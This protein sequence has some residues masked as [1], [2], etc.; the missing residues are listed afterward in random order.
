MRSLPALCSLAA[1]A[2]C[3]LAVTASLADDVPQPGTARYLVKF[4]SLKTAS[5]AV[6]AAGGQIA[7]E[8][9]RQR[10]AV[11]Y[12]S[13]DA[14]RRLKD[15]PNVESVEP[16]R[17]RYPMAQSTPY[18]IGLV[19]ADDPVLLAS[20]ASVGSMVCIID[21]GY[22]L[23]HEDL[24]GANI[25]GTN[26]SGT[27]N[28]YEDSCGHGTHVAGTVAALDNA[29]G[30]VGVNRNGLLGIHVEKVFDAATCAW[31]Y[32]SDIIAALNRCQD[33]A[34]GTGQ[35]LVVNMSLSG[36]QPSA[37]EEAAFQAAYDAGVLPVAAASNGGGT[38]L[39]Y[40]AGYPSVVSVAAVDS[41]GNVASFSQRN[42]DVELAAPGVG[43]VS[44][45]P[46]RVSGLHQGGD[47][48][49]GDNIIGSARIDAAGLLADGGLCDVPGEWT[50]ALVL[51]ERG[52]TPFADK[53]ANVLA[54]GGVGAVVYNNVAEPFTGTLNGESDIPAISLS[55]S[56]GQAA[57]ARLGAEASLVNSPGA[58]SSYV[59]K[60]GTSMASPHV[61]G[62]AALL[63]SFYPSKTNAEVRE[64]LQAT[65]LDKGTA[66]R[67][68]T[69][70]FG[71]IQAKAA[72]DYLGGILPPPPPP[73]PPPA[74]IELTVTK[75][76]S[77]G[78]RFARLNWGGA[79]GAKVNYFRN[80]KKFKTPNDGVQRDGPLALGTYTYKV[81]KL[82]TANCS[83]KVTITY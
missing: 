35:H 33:A 47:S 59:A 62:V 70:G 31:T 67:D 45:S 57:L 82:N 75:V 8:L 43:V 56:D 80:T 49:L 48:W 54:G 77:G 78:K 22:Y 13:E 44:T 16:D 42:A 69:Y 3:L 66:G 7:R 63:W 6:N 39:A 79:T 34:A 4:R 68:N 76:K 55:Q 50:S 72:Y 28:W 53:V 58:G 25:T 41:N 61:A 27:G 24:Q 36:P 17:K 60:D 18:G 29:V 40:P 12:L 38:T 14:L 20:N 51:C 15:D 9:G 74:D 65:A 2:A 64:A 32:S 11:A 52:V 19:Q 23:G 71:I 46:F 26:D 5:P 30:V 21:S 73:P 81:C 37:A 10:I 83:N 1:C